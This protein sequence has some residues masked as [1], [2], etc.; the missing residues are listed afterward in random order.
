MLKPT[1]AGIM[2]P[3]AKMVGKLESLSAACEKEF[4]VADSR[5][6]E[7]EAD[8]AAKVT[9]LQEVQDESVAE[10]KK[11]R[12]AINMINKLTGEVTK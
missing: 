5:I 10:L 4:D 6:M 2:K 8:A 7:V 12:R 9:S 11:A 3:F 1:V